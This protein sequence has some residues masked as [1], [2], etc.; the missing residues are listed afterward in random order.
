MAG[1]VLALLLA[2]STPGPA[3][4]PGWTVESLPANGPELLAA[5][6]QSAG[7]DRLYL[8]ARHR[9]GRHQ[10]FAQLQL[11]EGTAFAGRMPVYRIDDSP[12]YDTDQIR[13]AGD[14]RGSLWGDVSKQVAFWLVWASNEDVI[15]PGDPL[16]A[17]LAGKRLQVS[18]RA[19]DGTDHSIEFT[20]EGAA[21]A[22]L[23]A[24]GLKRE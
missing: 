16:D 2:G 15:R 3:A 11:A 4:T 20:L 13:R 12:P 23:S 6:V 18:F 10:V 1:F 8:W 7:G 24:T 9:S 21:G 19:D 17:W 5:G 22:V 14:A